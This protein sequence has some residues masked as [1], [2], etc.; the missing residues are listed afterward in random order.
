MA[1]TSQQSANKMAQLFDR[2]TNYYVD[3]V[4]LNRLADNSI[5]KTLQEL[6]PDSQYF[7]ESEVYSIIELEEGSYV[8]VGLN[9]NT[10]ND[11][12]VV[13]SVVPGSPSEKGGIRKGD[14]IIAIN[15]ENIAGK[16]ISNNEVSQK[17]RGTRST[18]VTTDI[19]RRGYPELLPFR[20]VRDLIPTPQQA[21]FK[22]KQLFDLIDNNYAGKVDSVD[23]NN[24]TDNMIRRIL[25]EL[26]PHSQYLTEPEVRMMNE[27]WEGYDGIGVSQII[28]NDTI[29]IYLTV[30]DGPSEKAG[31]KSGDKIIAINGEN[32]AGKGVSNNEALQKL[33]GAGGTEVM[34][35]VLRRGYPELLSFRVVRDK[36]PAYSIDAAYIVNNK[37]GYI[38]LRR[39]AA[40]TKKEFDDAFQKFKNEGVTNL[41]LDLTGNGGGAI[42]AAVLL[43]NEFLKSGQLIYFAE[44]EKTPRRERWTNSNGQFATGKLALMIDEY[45]G[46]ASEL[47][48]GAIQD[49]DRGII[50]GR[51]SFGKGLIQN[52][53]MFTDGSMLKLTTMR[54]HTPSGRAIQK[55]YNIKNDEYAEEVRSRLQTGELTGQK[56]HI[57]NDSLRYF[58]LVKKRAVYGGGGIM[59]DIFVAIDTSHYTDYIRELSKSGIVSRFD[60]NYV[61]KNRQSLML[62]Y[63][64]F[65]QFDKDFTVTETMLDELQDFAQK[66]GL[67]RYPKIFVQSQQY[68]K[69]SIKGDIAYLLWEME[70]L[71]YRI[72]NEENSIFLQA[73]EVIENLD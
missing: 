18:E 56:Q 6:D 47:F 11:T 10:L 3:T 27:V 21:I 38:K 41:I 50:I 8:G 28:L 1:Q 45:T 25:H 12:I 55:P 48:A 67:K 5:R 52:N 54:Y 26:D 65:E 7:T 59:P 24:L 57:G 61:E 72:M 15:G 63:P 30:K 71:Y 62:Q 36:I 22:I 43:A 23:V 66:E 19:L 37:T 34:I 69:L 49:W 70:E 14:K 9:F 40:T 51:R 44:G 29:L 17:L 16:G 39:F 53:Y 20:I 31:I 73:V 60:I 35:D 64:T 68:L 32:V 4:N 13:S 58:T 42:D 46:S 2:I 33:R